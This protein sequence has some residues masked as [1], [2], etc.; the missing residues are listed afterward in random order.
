MSGNSEANPATTIGAGWTGVPEMRW[1][2]VTEIVA[3]IKWV[4]KVMP[5][6]TPF[7]FKHPID[8]YHP[9]PELCITPYRG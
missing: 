1:I 5:R 7:S 6:F 2:V 3:P 9:H 4:D 8:N